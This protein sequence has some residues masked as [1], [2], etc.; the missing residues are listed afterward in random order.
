MSVEGVGCAIRA[1]V[2][3]DASVE[4][5][6]GHQPAL[7]NVHGAIFNQRRT[8]IRRARMVQTPVEMNI[9]YPPHKHQ[10]T[11]L[12]AF[13]AWALANSSTTREE[14]KGDG[15]FFCKFFVCHNLLLL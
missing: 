13:I 14:K 11:R 8:E 9:I 15:P 1:G 7:Q 10:T 5:Q 4:G 2:L 12:R 6:T 3:H